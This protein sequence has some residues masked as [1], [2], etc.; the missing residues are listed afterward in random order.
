MLRLTNG[1]RSHDAHIAS[2][3]TDVNL[4]I[5]PP[6][7]HHRTVKGPVAPCLLLIQLIGDNLQTRNFGKVLGISRNDRNIPSARTGSNPEVRIIR[8][9]SKSRRTPPQIAIAIHRL[10]ILCQ[11][12]KARVECGKFLKP[13]A[14]V[15][16]PARELRL[17]YPWNLQ[18]RYPGILNKIRK[19]IRVLTKSPQINQDSRVG[20]QFQVA[21]TTSSNA[22][23]SSSE[24]F[25]NVCAPFRA[26]CKVPLGGIIFSMTSEK[27][28]PL[29]QAKSL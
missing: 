21:L 24:S 7:G 15:K 5:H 20:N 14:L 3:F 17:G 28:S 9:F 2:R 23:K 1:R 26:A 4:S 27:V 16:S 12:K 25:G 11:Q 29:F 19:P 8:C 22:L 18:G 10:L 6:H 13:D